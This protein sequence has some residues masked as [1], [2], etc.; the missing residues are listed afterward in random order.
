MGWGHERSSRRQVVAWSGSGAKVTAGIS[1]RVCIHVRDSMGIRVHARVGVRLRAYEREL[2]CLR[3][4][5]RARACGACAL[6]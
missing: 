6:W 5:V 3:C 4:C 2:V 1:T